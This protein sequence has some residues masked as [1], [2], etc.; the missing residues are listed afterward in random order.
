MTYWLGVINA[1]NTASCIKFNKQAHR[2]AHESIMNDPRFTKIR[3][4]TSD[5]RRDWLQA[6]ARSSAVLGHRHRERDGTAGCLAGREGGMLV[7]A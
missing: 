2:S 7:C 3:R 1:D 5:H 6:H 4:S